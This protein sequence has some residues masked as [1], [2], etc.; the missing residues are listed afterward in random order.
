MAQSPQ[1][2]IMNKELYNQ[3]REQNGQEFR[4]A[5]PDEI[6][7]G[8]CVWMHAYDPNVGR[9]WLEGPYFVTEAIHEGRM[10]EHFVIFST[11][12]K[13]ER[14]AKHGDVWIPI[15][16]TIERPRGHNV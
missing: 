10:S 6:H 8:E 12:M 5:T 7:V 14:R 4:R 16:D 15:I 1:G 3:V 9:S 11:H 13:E 2:E